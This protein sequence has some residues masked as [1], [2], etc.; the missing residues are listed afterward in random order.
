MWP[1]DRAPAGVVLRRSS[2]LLIAAGAGVGMALLSYAVMTRPAP[3]SISRYF[4]ERAYAEGGGTNVVNV[5]LVDFRGFDTLG[6]ITVLCIV[7]LT[8]FSLLRRFRPAAESV[9]TPLQQREQ[10]A[11]DAASPHRAVGDTAADYMLAPQ[12]IME[13][14]FPAIIVFALY[15]LL[16]GHDL[17]GGGFAAG[18][19]MSIA[20]L[21]QYMARGT[22]QTEMLLAI[23][24]LL[25]IGLGL[26]CA[27]ATGAGAW[28]FGYPFLTSEFGYVSLPIIDAVPLASALLF[29]LGVFALVVGATVLILIALAHQSI[30]VPRAA[31][32]PE[33]SVPEGGEN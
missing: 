15:L 14:L 1:E 28:L 27:T 7:A 5:I 29:D 23:R 16:R 13:W 21:S 24:P 25:W 33:L 32:E 8:I 3:A 2:D 9:T 22:R 12:A 30:R 31:R 20:I 17:P 10:N 11:S 4:L 26:L 19:A 18:V 6:E